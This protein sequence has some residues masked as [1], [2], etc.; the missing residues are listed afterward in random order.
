[1]TPRRRTES[2][3]AAAPGVL[4]TL[5]GL[6]AGLFVAML[7]TSLV[8]T[9]LPRMVDDIGGT[10]A[11]LTWIVTATLL[12]ITIS[13]PI[14]GKLSDLFSRRLLLIAALSVFVVGSVLAGAAASPLLLIAGRALQGIGAGGLL[15]LVNIVL[16]DVVSPRDRGRYMGLIGAVMAVGTVGGPLIGGLVT[17]Q[18]GWRWNFYG[19]AVLAVISLV[20]V[21]LTVP[22]SG[23]RGGRSIDYGGAVLITAGVSGLLIWASLAGEQFDWISPTSALLLAGSLLLLAA[24]VLVE[25]IVREPII[26]LALFRN[27]AYV[28]VVIAS[29][30]VGV[31]TYGVAIFMSQYLQVSRGSTPTASGLV[32]MPQLIGVTVA[33]TVVGALISRTGRWKVWMIVG[34]AAQTAGL[35]LLGTMGVSTPVPLLM[36][37]LGLIGLGIGGIMQNLVLVAE[38]SVDARQLGV[39]T[40]GVGFFRTLGGSLGVVALGAVV[41]WR[42]SSLILAG[43]DAEDIRLD[44]IDVT[45]ISET[46]GIPASLEPIV[47]EAYARGIADS[48]LVCAVLAACALV[49]IALLPAVPLSTKTR[50][51]RIAES[52]AATAIALAGGEPELE[53]R[54]PAAVRTDGAPTARVRRRHTP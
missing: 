22:R 4:R 34:C 17:D 11:A 15:S 6:L 45:R 44:G 36:V 41:S 48:Y 40:A 47:Q 30:S 25:R 3:A 13:T 7:A 21:W 37:Y 39:A 52:E 5:I 42:S 14:W 16:A 32:T 10:Q 53:P 51:E 33:S 20:L 23:R 27:R 28:L 2:G 24:A 46:T 1:M 35:A 12:T 38:N 9:S 18:W 43:A 8:A 50:A 49:C 54:S 26:P 31:A 19:S 29:V